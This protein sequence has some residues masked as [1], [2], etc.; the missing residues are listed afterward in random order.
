MSTMIQ[1][2]DRFT[3]LPDEQTLAETCAAL[4]ERGFSVEVV[5]D[6]DAAGR[7]DPCNRR[8]LMRGGVT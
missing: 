6:L 2:S 7:P 5:D 8:V 4:G 3:V 1:T